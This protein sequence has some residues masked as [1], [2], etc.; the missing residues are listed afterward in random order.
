MSRLTRRQT[1][2]QD[3]N[4]VELNTS[5]STDSKSSTATMSSNDSS[6]V[7]RSPMTT[8]QKRTTRQTSIFSFLT[9]KETDTPD[10]RDTDTNSETPTKRRAS[11]RHRLDTSEQEVYNDEVPSTPSRR[12]QRIQKSP[13]SVLKTDNDADDKVDVQQT[14]TRYADTI[15]PADEAIIAALDLTA[16]AK[17]VVDGKVPDLPFGVR[18]ARR[19]RPPGTPSKKQV[20]IRRY[21]EQIKEALYRHAHMLQAGTAVLVDGIFEEVAPVNEIRV[22]GTPS[23]SVRINGKNEHA[24]SMTEPKETSPVITGKRKRLAS[25]L[26]NKKRQSMTLEIEEENDTED[27]YKAESNE[28]EEEDI[29]DDNQEEEEEE[30][31]EEDT[32]EEVQRKSNRPVSSSSS[33][34]KLNKK[35]R[36]SGGRKFTGL[37]KL[38]VKSKSQISKS[39]YA[40]AEWKKLSFPTAT[41]YDTQLNQLVYNSGTSG[42]ATKQKRPTGKIN[43]HEEGLFDSILGRKLNRRC[44]MALRRHAGL[45][46]SST[47]YYNAIPVHLLPLVRP[48]PFER[49]VATP[50]MY[51]IIETI[52]ED[53]TAELPINIAFAQDVE[54]VKSIALHGNTKIPDITGFIINTGINVWA[55]EWCPRHTIEAWQYLAIAG[56]PATDVIPRAIGLPE[57]NTDWNQLQFWRIPVDDGEVDANKVAPMLDAIMLHKW[58]TIWDMAWCPG[59]SDIEAATTIAEESDSNHGRQGILALCCGDGH[60]RVVVVP[61]IKQLRDQH[62]TPDSQPV[63]FEIVTTLLDVSLSNACYIVA[64]WDNDGRLASAC[65]DGTVVLWDLNE[66]ISQTT[67]PDEDEEVLE[68]AGVPLIRF[69]SHGCLIRSLEWRRPILSDIMTSAQDVYSNSTSKKNASKHVE[70]VRDMRQSVMT[71]IDMDAY[72]QFITVGYDGRININDRRYPWQPYCLQRNRAMLVCGVWPPGASVVLYADQEY[73]VRNTQIFGPY[74]QY[75]MSHNSVA[76]DIGVSDRHPYAASVGADGTLQVNNPF[77]NPDEMPRIA[78][79]TVYR[80]SYD[81]TSNVYVFNDKPFIEEMRKEKG[82]WMLLDFHKKMSLQRARWNQNPGSASHWIA[83]G[84]ASGLV[85]VDSMLRDHYIHQIYH[86]SKTATTTNNNNTKTHRNTA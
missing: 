38:D 13:I 9:R 19:G 50:A 44:T 21:R 83:S 30:E 52:P 32:Y 69:V 26:G 49:V 18:C 10:I 17:E 74:W 76:W 64:R 31:E 55:M 48:D 53:I 5:H 12:S 42:A 39:K 61:N 11:K 47:V 68:T 80:L 24:S 34:K 66:I 28:E 58:G 57:S 67:S 78:Q 73:M 62:N 29:E 2:A 14:S 8:P 22:I 71:Q 33:S 51:Q 40:N 84:G 25:I 72:Q 1:R 20:A 77:R 79:Y 56:L 65:T 36:S 63:H 81:E 70:S 37:I 86:M 6:N 4:D 59:S 45:F 85:R 16:L 27:E 35:T 7:S 75:I 60:L 23:R 41:T 54:T 43:K 82:S 46:C 15:S 3:N